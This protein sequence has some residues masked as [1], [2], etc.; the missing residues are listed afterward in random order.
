MSQS[1]TVAP[2]GRFCL[3]SR[4]EIWP[5]PSSRSVTDLNKDQDRDVRDC[6][7]RPEIA[8]GCS[9]SYEVVLHKSPFSE[10]ID[11]M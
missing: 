10:G 8:N 4:G 6:D 9:G 5:R 3:A 2:N 1:S 11:I 7:K